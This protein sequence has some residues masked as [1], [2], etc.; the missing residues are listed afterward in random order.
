MLEAARDYQSGPRVSA[1]ACESSLLCN[2]TSSKY[3]IEYSAIFQLCVLF[4]QVSYMW[5]SGNVKGLRDGLMYYF[6]REMARSVS[7]RV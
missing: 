6:L 1:F 7:V 5:L 2:D 3:V 4:A